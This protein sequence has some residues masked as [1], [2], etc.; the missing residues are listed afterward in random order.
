MI[1]SYKILIYLQFTD[2]AMVD[3]CLK[4]KYTIVI[5]V[6]IILILKRINQSMHI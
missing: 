6:Q 1:F 2:P 5:I 4:I 3:Y